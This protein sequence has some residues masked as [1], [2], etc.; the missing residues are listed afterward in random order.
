MPTERVDVAV[1]SRTLLR[2]SDPPP[3]FPAVLQASNLDLILGSFH[4]YL[5]AMYP[6]PAA[7]FPAVVAA[8]R[9]AMPAFLSRFFPFAGRV[10]A[11]ADTGVPEIACD[12]TG[13]ELVVARAGVRLADVDFADADR[14]LGRIAVP[15]QQDL[16]LSLQLVRFAC[17]GF[18]LSWGTNHLLVD[19]HGLTALPSAWAEL[20]RTG[21]LSW[22]PHHERASLFR[23]RDPPRYSAS[24]DAEFT[25]Y[26]PAGLPNS[27]L[28]ATLVR[29]NYVVSAA[30]V[31]RLRAAASTPARRATRLEALSAHVWKLLAAAVGGLDAHCR[32]AW[33]V[34][35]RPRLDAARY[36]GATVRRYLGNVL[37]Y[38][39]REAAVEAVSSSPLA[40]VAAMAG[41]AIAEVFRWERYEELV[42]WMEVHKGVFREGGK[43]TEVVG[44]GMG[45]P[46]LVVSTF[47]PFRVEGDFGFGRP[48]LVFPWVRPGRLGSAAMTVSRSPR[49]DGSWLITARMWPRLADAV[50]ADPD[51]VLKPATAA[52]LG[53][54]APD[55]ADVMQHATSRM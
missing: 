26:A 23:P 20:L 49:E 21:G 28:T 30:D 55:P 18:A 36:D 2:A 51:A 14:S 35:G 29:R 19:G 32:M 7:G 42:D 40:D 43:W 27:L 22:E 24:L 3:D 5:I 13:A 25:R 46:A 11:N 31:D 16:A 34:D 50:D 41:A 47:V 15:F 4:I 10:V 33:L 44:T 38:A 53:F 45:S 48:R 12:N 54:G 39:S 6:A 52:R 8:A 37:T 1:S 9:D 17:G